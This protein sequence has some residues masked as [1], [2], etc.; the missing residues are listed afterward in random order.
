LIARVIDIKNFTHKKPKTK[1]W[2]RFVK[3]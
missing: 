2:F 1:N 3:E